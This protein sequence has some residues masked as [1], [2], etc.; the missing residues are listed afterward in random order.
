L[1]CRR[2]LFGWPPGAESAVS[3]RDRPARRG[4]LVVRHKCIVKS[5]CSATR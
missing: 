2:V 4:L 1:L 5:G 3:R